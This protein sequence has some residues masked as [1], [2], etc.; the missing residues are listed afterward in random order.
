MHTFTACIGRLRD[1]IHIRLKEIWMFLGLAADP[2]H[3]ELL[4][5]LQ[6]YSLINLITLSPVV[7]RRYST[8]T[9]GAEGEVVLTD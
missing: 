2:Q 7:L 4:C 8:T 1:S 9:F 5:F 6:R 3:P